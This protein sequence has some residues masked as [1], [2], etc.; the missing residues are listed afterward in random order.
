MSERALWDLI[1]P[2]LSPFGALERIENRC[3]K[4]TP[5]VSYVLSLPGR[6][7][8]EGR[9]ETKH[10]DA[11][12]KRETTLITIDCLTKDQVLWH[13]AWE[14]AGGRTCVLLR[15]GKGANADFLFMSPATTRMIYQKDLT[16]DLLLDMC[17]RKTVGVHVRT[18]LEYL[19]R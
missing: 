13:E 15:V 7:P 2:K 8:V 17:G 3:G 16:K 11:W 5:D 14:G 10:L 4:G 12:P 6:P 19:T 1:R 9:I 18:W